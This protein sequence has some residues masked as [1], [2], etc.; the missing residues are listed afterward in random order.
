MKALYQ[1]KSMTEIF[2][3]GVVGEEYIKLGSVRE[4]FYIVLN[5]KTQKIT[6][7]QSNTGCYPII[8][9]KGLKAY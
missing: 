9:C 5:L 6:Q 7:E 3:F 1:V 8:N 4:G 2:N